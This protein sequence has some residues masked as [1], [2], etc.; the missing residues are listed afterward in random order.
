MQTVLGGFVAFLLPVVSVLSKTCIQVSK[1]DPN[2]ATGCLLGRPVVYTGQDCLI[3]L[4]VV[5]IVNGYCSSWEYPVYA[6][7][8]HLLWFIFREPHISLERAAYT[9]SAVRVL[10][11]FFHLNYGVFKLTSGAVVAPSSLDD[12]IW[13]FSASYLVKPKTGGGLKCHKSF[14]D[15]F[16]G[17]LYLVLVWI[18]FQYC[19][20]KTHTKPQ[21]N[22]SD[23]CMRCQRLIFL[24]LCFI[25][26]RERVW[27]D[28]EILHIWH[29]FWML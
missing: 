3:F 2:P 12:L 9:F 8:L 11:C 22:G 16:L 13:C 4:L 18:F 10:F 5:M 14:R 6:V 15:W 26:F 24:S 27:S 7:W 1:N 17:W 23:V 28:I 20:R 29:L 25:W 19:F 21:G